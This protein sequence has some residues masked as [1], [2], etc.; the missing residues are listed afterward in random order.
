MTGPTTRRRTTGPIL[1]RS[2][3]GPITRRSTRGPITKRT[4]V[5]GARPQGGG[6][7]ARHQGGGRQARYEGGRQRA[8]PART[9]AAP[10]AGLA[11]RRWRPATTT[12]TRRR[13]RR[14]SRPPRRSERER[15]GRR[16][17][18]DDGAKTRPMGKRTGRTRSKD[19]RLGLHVLLVSI[20]RERAPP[21]D[22]AATTDHR[23]REV[24]RRRKIARRGPRAAG[25]RRPAGSARISV[26]R[27]GPAPPGWTEGEGAAGPTARGSRR[28]ASRGT[29]NEKRIVERKET[30]NVSSPRKGCH[31]RIGRI[32]LEMTA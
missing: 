10:G 9:R 7:R 17:T 2:T 3:A 5:R 6:R 8:R 22:A 24:T 29:K 25:G 13:R 23:S 31:L 28:M 27:R 30:R 32:F 26:G 21:L 20:G 11:S 4:R 18:K 14:T 19:A 15:R 12:T 16:G 1:R